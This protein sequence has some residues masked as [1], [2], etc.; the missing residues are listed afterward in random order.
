MQGRMFTAIKDMVSAL[1]LLTG[2]IREI[3][4]HI[5]KVLKNSN[6]AGLKIKSSIPE[7]MNHCHIY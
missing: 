5:I 3:P 4:I 7:E 2:F 6:I 1:R